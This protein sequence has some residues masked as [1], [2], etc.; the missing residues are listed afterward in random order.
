[1]PSVVLFHTDKYDII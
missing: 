1:M